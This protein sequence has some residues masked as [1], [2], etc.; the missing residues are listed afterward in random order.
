MF[1]KLFR[2][3]R[4]RS[5]ILG[6]SRRTSRKT[7]F[8]GQGR[9]S[10]RMQYKERLQSYLRCNLEINA[11]M[12]RT[13]NLLKIALDAFRKVHEKAGIQEKSQILSLLTKNTAKFFK[14]SNRV[15][16]CLQTRFDALEK[17]IVFDNVHRRTRAQSSLSEK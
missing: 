15:F 12:Q 13:E 14:T 17:Q 3:F 6:C 4:P 2:K 5:I 10:K 8:G 9:I 7:F 16:E 11:K 1:E